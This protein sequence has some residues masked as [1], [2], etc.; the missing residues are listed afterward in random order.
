MTVSN[1][2][3]PFHDHTQSFLLYKMLLCLFHRHEH[4]VKSTTHIGSG[5]FENSFNIIA[6]DYIHA[7]PETN[8]NNIY[9]D[10]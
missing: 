1:S 9:S 5:G 4:L 8:Y 2:N 10:N 3:S 6:D 7:T